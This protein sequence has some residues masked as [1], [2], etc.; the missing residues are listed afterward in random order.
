MAYFRHKKYLRKKHL[1]IKEG[2]KKAN[3]FPY[4]YP[5]HTYNNGHENNSNST[6]C[7]LVKHESF[8]RVESKKDLQSRIFYLSCWMNK[9]LIVFGDKNE[10]III[11][12]MYCTKLRDAY[13]LKSHRPEATIVFKIVFKRDTI[14]QFF[15]IQQEKQPWPLWFIT[16][17]SKA[18]CS[19]V[20]AFS[21]KGRF[22]DD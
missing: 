5:L 19:I 6:A 3:P 1:H 20:E 4:K 13:V 17:Q 9:R 22:Y 12:K 15:N 2:E 21:S 7:K 16:G 8:R 10:K 18:I 11:Y 14:F